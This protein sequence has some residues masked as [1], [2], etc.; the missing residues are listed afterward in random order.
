MTAFFGRPSPGS[1][2]R[3]NHAIKPSEGASTAPSEASPKE[4]D[5]AG[6]AAAR[7]RHLPAAEGAHEADGRGSASGAQEAE[8][9]P[10]ARR[11][12]TAAGEAYLPYVEPAAEGAHEADGPLSASCLQG[13]DEVA[14]LGDQ[15]G[16][17]LVALHQ[18]HDG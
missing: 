16:R 6:N 11:R 7:T 3:Q 1:F 17:A 5:R 14:D 13:G 12:P 9:G 15:R 2:R 4:Q 8:Q 18:V 10:D